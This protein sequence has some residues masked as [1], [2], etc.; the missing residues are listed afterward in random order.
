VD[1]TAEAGERQ[2]KR[3]RVFAEHLPFSAVNNGIRTGSLF[4]G[5][6]NVNRNYP[7]EGKVTLSGDRKVWG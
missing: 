7:Y 6:V 5:K 4:S 3:K 2:Q 1:A